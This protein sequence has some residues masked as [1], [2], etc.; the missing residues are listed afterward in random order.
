MNIISLSFLKKE[1]YIRVYLYC[2]NDYQ[3][4]EIQNIIQDIQ[5]LGYQ[6][7]L[8]QDDIY[9]GNRWQMSEIVLILNQSDEEKE[10]WQ[11]MA[12][13]ENKKIFFSLAELEDYAQKNQKW[14]PGRCCR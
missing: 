5:D 10:I 12:E 13:K 14:F 6:V 2:K 3:D 4:E 8:S 1:V 9:D 7:L 11:K